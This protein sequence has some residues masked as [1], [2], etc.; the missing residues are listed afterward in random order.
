MPK[1]K[2][3]NTA[4]S[5]GAFEQA[6]DK[7]ETERLTFAAFRRRE[8]IVSEGK[9]QAWLERMTTES[10]VPC[11]CADRC[12]AEPDGECPHGHPSVLVAAGLI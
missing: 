2:S 5:F 3:P 12:E 6:A 8:G 9:W 7:P 10:S 4:T 1:K 11:L